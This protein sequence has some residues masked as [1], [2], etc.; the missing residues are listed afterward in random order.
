VTWFKLD[1]SF[2]DHPKV[3]DAPDCAVALWTRAACWSA[4]NLTEGFVPSG[5]AARLCDDPETAA[6]ELVR[7][8]LWERTGGG[9]RFHDWNDFQPSKEEATAA[10]AN[11]S[12]GGTLG[13]HR[14]WHVDKG[15]I[16]P[17]CAFCQQ[18]QVSGNRSGSDRVGD[19]GTESHPNP[20]SRPV[21]SLKTKSKPSPQPAAEDPLF[22]EFW[23]AY[24]RRVDKG[25]A[26]KAWA[27]K[28]KSGAD[29]NAII[30]G[31]IAY[32][33]NPGRPRDPKFVPH[34]A[35]WLNGERWTDE[36]TPQRPPRPRADDEWLYQ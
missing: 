6:R 21:P 22:D 1:D 3:F 25:H 14:R 16:R 23:T 32:R 13:N 9:Y 4:R 30:K 34:P 36:T 26:R 18:E 2:Y 8:G 20:P 10:K 28:V 19:G 15:E 11:Q 7:R 35:T 17:G 31:A 24:P 29:P 12:S 27:A 5:M 33:D